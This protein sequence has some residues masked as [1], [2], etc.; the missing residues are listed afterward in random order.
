MGRLVGDLLTLA[1]VDA[2]FASPR[3]RVNVS[4]IVTD[5]VE[6]ASAVDR[7]RTYEIVGLDDVYVTGDEAHLTQMVA[8][9]LGNISSHCPAGTK[10]K[11]SLRQE[12]GDPLNPR[13]GAQSVSPHS[14]QTHSGQPQI[15]AVVRVSDDGPGISADLLPRL[16]ERFTRRAT[17]TGGV[18][19]GLAIVSALASEHG[20]T[21]AL[22]DNRPGHTTFEIRLP[23]SA[24]T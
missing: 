9:L 10:A 14:G 24:H 2:G 8:N 15:V 23:A 12:T 13:V 1:S 5:A 16:F 11:V 20:G 6:D 4:G 17:G 7:D 18:G 22:I 19:L 21:V 3:R